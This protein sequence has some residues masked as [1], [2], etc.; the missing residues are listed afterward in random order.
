MKKWDGYPVPGG[1][2]QFSL[3]RGT[4]SIEVVRRFKW[5]SVHLLIFM[6]ALDDGSKYIYLPV[7][8]TSNNW[9][10]EVPALLDLLRVL[11]V[12]VA[13]TVDVYDDRVLVGKVEIDK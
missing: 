5:A 6:R 9:K 4:S 2:Y 11:G 10:E 12:R 3:L 8:H 1:L 7:D 13:D